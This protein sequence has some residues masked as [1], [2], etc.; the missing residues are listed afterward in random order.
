MQ[1]IQY[2][3]MYELENL[4]WWFFAKRYY[5]SAILPNKIQH[6]NILDI[7]SGTGGLTKYLE[8]WGSVYGI[9]N[10]PHAKVYLQKRNVKFKSISVL[11]YPMPK[12][13][14]DVIILCDVLYHKNIID[15]EKVIKKTFE[16]LKKG[17]LLY[18]ADSACKSLYSNHDISMQARERYSLNEMAEKVTKSGFSIKKKTYCYFFLFPLFIIQRMLA[19]KRKM[20]TLRKIPGPLNNLLLT[21]CKIESVLLQK[22]SFP[23]GSSIIILAQKT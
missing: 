11:N 20:E 8:K 16:G 3:L 19:K 13:K 10:S 5:L 23:F 21:V 14:F 15:D 2:Q 9:E 6:L 12:E 1:K 4:H 17:G 18:I 22:I 7:G